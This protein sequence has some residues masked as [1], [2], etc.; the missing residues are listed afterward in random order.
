MIYTDK[1]TYLPYE[2]PIKFKQGEICTVNNYDEVCE[3]VR[4]KA[5]EDGFY[6]RPMT[7]IVMRRE[8]IIEGQLKYF[9]TPVSNT[10]RPARLFRLPATHEI[11][12]NNPNVITDIRK[13]DGQFIIYLT[14]FMFG[15]RIQFHEW[16]FDGKVPVRKNTDFFTYHAD[17]EN[18]I[19]NAY[20]IWLQCSDQHRK[21]LI[22]LLY[23]QQKI[24]SYEWDWERFFISYMVLDSCYKFFREKYGMEKCSHRDRIEKMLSYCDMKFDKDRVGRI[25]ELRNNLIHES[26]WNNEQPGEGCG[27]QQELDIFRINCRLILAMFGYRGEYVESPWWFGGPF[28]FN[29]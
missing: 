28:V 18:V 5:N 14:A 15:V 27:H 26:L 1:I 6:Y 23:M 3:Y 24:Q 25:V 17:I 9:E 22:N 12:I 13:G 20:E 11:K 29:S 7:E 4:C 21:F 8:E 19:G 16:R 10:K 2:T